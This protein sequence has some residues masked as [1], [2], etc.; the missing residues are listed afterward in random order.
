MK[1]FSRSN[2][3][4]HT[5]N[6][7]RSDIQQHVR[8]NF[9]VN[10]TDGAFFGGAQGFAST[11]AVIPLFIA[12]LTDSKTIIGLIPAIHAIGWFLPQLLTA[13]LVARQRRFKNSV[14]L[15]T[16]SERLPFFLL[17]LVAWFS[18]ELGATNTLILAL[19]ILSW[20]ALGGGITATGWQSMISKIIPP[21]RR[22]V[23]YGTQSAAAAL[24]GS[25]TVALA[26]IILKEVPT[27]LNYTLCFLLCSILMLISW[28]FLASTREPE[29]EPMRTN[30]QSWGELRR[31]LMTILKTDHNYRWFV[32]ARAAAQFAP[33]PVLFY[34]I[35]AK[36][37]YQLDEATIGLLAGWLTLSQMLA[38]PLLGWAGDRW[39]HRRIFMLGGLM[40]AGSSLLVLLVHSTTGLYLAYFLAGAANAVYWSTVLSL[41]VEFGTEAKRPYYVSLIST[42]IAPAA[43]VAALMG[44]LLADTVSYDATFILGITA[45][46]IMVLLMVVFVRNPRS[47]E[48]KDTQ[49][50]AQVYS[51]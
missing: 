41:T 47:S 7:L 27:P 35:F 43:L 16:L 17:A 5:G 10:I 42:L 1:R 14:I 15:L 21:E 3:N 32:V 13:D 23:F 26:G 8:H 34:A 38:A 18:G 11:Y 19:I 28:A 51:E 29:S 2:H 40:S 33:M 12:T 30:K 46:I 39:G 45:S 44:G 37:R 49:T 48:I 36:E 4:P 50:L 22:G 9:V 25:V 20:Q 24:L 6:L 31:E